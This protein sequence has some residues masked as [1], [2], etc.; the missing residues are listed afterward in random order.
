MLG[1]AFAAVAAL[2]LTIIVGHALGAAGTG[3]FYQAVGI[4]TVLTQVLRLGT[5]SGVV[6]FISEQRAFGRTGSEW[7]IIGFAAIPVAALSTAVS[8]AVWLAA[9]P[10]AEWLSDPGSDGLSA[11]VLRAMAPF[12]VVAAVLGVVEIAARMVRG[13]GTFTLLQ[14]VMLPAS[15]LLTVSLVT[16]AGAT[17]YEAFGAWTAPL[18][19]WL[20]V[21]VAVIASPL[22]RDFRCRADSPAESRPRFTTF[23]RFNL[24][25]AVSSAL[26]VGLEWADVLIVAALAS[27][28][29]AGVY[30]VVTRAIK[31]GGIV[32]HG[33]RIAVGPTISAMLARK[34]HVSATALHTRVVRAMILMNWPFY[35]LLISLGPAVLAVFGSEFVAGAGP[36]ALI[37]AGFMFQTAS[38]MLQSILLQGGKSTWQM[39][40][41][42]IALTLSVVGNLL[43][44]PVWGIWGAAVTWLVVL[45]VDN[46]IAAW[47]VHFRMGVVLQPA[48]LAGAALVPVAV[49]GIGGGLLRGL[50]GTNVLAMLLAAAGLAVIYLAAL[51][52][53][54]R[55][56]AIVELWR[57]VPIVG[58]YA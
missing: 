29:T 51:W 22:I 58:R 2:V 19:L 12:I 48:K 13:A 54:R 20:V 4:F 49:F 41:K 30:A 47:Q 16:L 8:V 21:G 38:G 28:S 23:W 18:P 6:R 34:E 40:N 15:R 35:L 37:A 39:Y 50:V 26:E 5:N 55:R 46:L 10:L 1:S 32:D 17:A 53:L 3:I 27:P 57:K 33:M 44:V 9:A 52:L 25:R 36:M 31:A 43:L 42:S 7:R 45:I 14:N 11:D 56:L 24:P